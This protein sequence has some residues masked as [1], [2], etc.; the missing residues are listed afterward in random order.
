MH[1]DVISNFRV[2]NR[3]VIIMRILRHIDFIAHSFGEV[4]MC[5]YNF[6]YRKRQTIFKDFSPHGSP[7]MRL[8]NV[9]IIIMIIIMTVSLVMV[10]VAVM[11]VMICC[12]CLLF[13][14]VIVLGRMTIIIIILCSTSTTVLT[15]SGG[16][17]R[18]I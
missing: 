9:L 2:P 12:C 6:K 3:A 11:V 5:G 14:V 10:H 13:A 16:I 15:C 8:L 1:S 4:V 17:H 7:E 18:H